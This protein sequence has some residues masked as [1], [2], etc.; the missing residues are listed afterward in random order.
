MD[1]RHAEVVALHRWAVIAEATSD[2]LEPAERGVVV[3]A[4]TT[5]AHTH[6]DGTLRH[7]SRASIDRWIRAWRR[8]GL[9]ALRP[10]TRSDTG[11]VPPIPSWPTRPPHCASSCRVARRPRSPGSFSPVTASPSPSARCANS[12]NAAG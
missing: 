6:P 3:R 1:E 9:E 10:E 2:R 4:K 8:G 7:Y 12:F 5:R 11:A